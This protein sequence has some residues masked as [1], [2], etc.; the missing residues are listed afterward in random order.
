[1]ICPSC[2][3]WQ[4]T[5][6]SCFCTVLF[7]PP[8]PH[9]KGVGGDLLYVVTSRTWST[10]KN[11]PGIFIHLS[12]LPA[13]GSRRTNHRILVQPQR[14]ICHLYVPVGATGKYRLVKSWQHIPDIFVKVL[15]RWA[16]GNR[17][18]NRLPYLSLITLSPPGTDR[19]YGSTR[20]TNTRFQ[21]LGIRKY[22]FRFLT[23]GNSLFFKKRFHGG[24]EIRTHGKRPMFCRRRHLLRSWSVG[25]KLKG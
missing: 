23:R 8:P 1:M 7:R 5:S 19:I 10:A 6:I 14:D 3:F 2:G 15:L 25:L 24:R 21:S 13:S 12:P 9:L 16:K 20:D 11:I 17:L 22:F 18:T 4:I